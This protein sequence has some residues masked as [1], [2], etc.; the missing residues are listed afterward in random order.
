MSLVQWKCVLAC[1]Q[2]PRWLL[3]S[4]VIIKSLPLLCLCQQSIT[5]VPTHPAVCREI[6]HSA[7]TVYPYCS[8]F[9]YSQKSIEKSSKFSHLKMFFH[10]HQ[11]EDQN[12]CKLFFPTPNCNQSAN[13]LIKW[14][15]QDLLNLTKL[16][17][18]QMRFRCKQIEHANIISSESVFNT[19]VVSFLR[20]V[21][22]YHALFVFTVSMNIRLF[23][24]S[25][26]W[27]QL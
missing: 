4:H 26:Y 25:L 12:G 6:C 24:F 8:V 7:Q 2:C 14:S 20:S 1:W 22:H 27:L 18:C 21:C 17:P 19:R 13:W 23:V 11:S 10:Q 3:V 9:W 5:C 15:F 16:S